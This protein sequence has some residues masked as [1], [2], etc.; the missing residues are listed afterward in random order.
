MIDL[1]LVG[2]VVI[3]LNVLDSVTTELGFRLPKHLRSKESN[4]FAK[5]WLEKS[6]KSAHIFKQ[7][8]VI[9]IVAFLIVFGDMRIM[10]M[11]AVMLGL[12]VANNSYI[13]IG[14]KITKRKMHTPFHKACKAC[15]IP[16]NC[17]YFVWVAL[18]IA[19]LL[20]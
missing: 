3:L 12:V 5:G 11:L 13:W 7:V 9:A 20:F 14:R 19:F 15:H 2:V 16:E 10:V 18:A 6:P 4:P 1:I 8:A 17:M